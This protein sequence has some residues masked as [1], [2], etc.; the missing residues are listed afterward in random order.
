MSLISR[1]V[2]VEVRHKYFQHKNKRLE[3]EKHDLDKMIG[4]LD[5][6]LED[7]ISIQVTRH[8]LII[9]M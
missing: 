5:R 8:G 4:F 3:E 6:E 1:L 2:S 7:R 9:S